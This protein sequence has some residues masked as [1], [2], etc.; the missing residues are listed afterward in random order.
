MSTMLRNASRHIL[1][2][3]KT[4][5]QPLVC[6]TDHRVRLAHLS[7]GGHLNQAIYAEISE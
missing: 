3:W 1:R 7:V 4:P 5:G 6:R 2:A